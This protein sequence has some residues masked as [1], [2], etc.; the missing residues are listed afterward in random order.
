M[1]TE[2]SVQANVAVVRDIYDRFN[3]RDLDGALAHL[4]DDFEMLDVPM[5]LTLRGPEGFRQWLEPFLAAMPDSST[6]ITNVVAA[7]DWIATEHTGRGTHTGPLMTPNGEV[8]PTGRPMELKFAE[9]FRL[10]DGKVVEFRAYYDSATLLR[11]L[12]LI[13]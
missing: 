2:T 1:A 3:R 6:E 10:R 9:L 4:G 13:S 7:G 8:P 11:Q 12:G 5:G